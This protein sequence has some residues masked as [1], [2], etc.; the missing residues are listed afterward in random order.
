MP[1]LGAAAASGAISVGAGAVLAQMALAAAAGNHRAYVPQPSAGSPSRITTCSNPS[2]GPGSSAVSSS[3]HG[4]S[5][6]LRGRYGA[7]RGQLG[8]DGLWRRFQGWWTRFLRH[9]LGS[10]GHVDGLGLQLLGPELELGTVSGGSDQRD[11]R[12]LSARGVGFGIGPGLD[13]AHQLGSTH[14]GATCLGS[15]LHVG[16]GLDL[17]G[18]EVAVAVVSLGGLPALGDFALEAGE[19]SAKDGAMCFQ[20]LLAEYFRRF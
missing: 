14:H 11:V 16:A 2:G 1:S 6:G 5:A 4:P 9:L 12:L 20:Q 18:D 7:L 3:P 10:G 13:Q 15:E 17:T 19:E 8:S